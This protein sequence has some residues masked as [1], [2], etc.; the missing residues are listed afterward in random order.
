MSEKIC[1]LTQYRLPKSGDCDKRDCAFLISSGCAVTV[2]ARMADE[3][4]QAIQDLGERLS[5]KV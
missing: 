5:N 1:P 4:F 3:G 2:A